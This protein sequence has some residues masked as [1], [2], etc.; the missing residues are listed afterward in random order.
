MNSVLPI[1]MLPARSPIV[2]FLRKTYSGLP[3][4]MFT[5]VGVR[6]IWH[7][8]LG[9]SRIYPPEEI[10]AG[11]FIPRSAVD[12]ATPP[13]TLGDHARQIP[14]ALATDHTNGYNQDWSPWVCYYFFRS[15]SLNIP[16]SKDMIVF[17]GFLRDETEVV[18]Q[19]LEK[20]TVCNDRVKGKDFLAHLQYRHRTT[21]N[22]QTYSCLWHR[23]SASR[24][25]IKSSLERHMREQH[26]PVKWACPTCTRTF[27]R[28]TTL[29]GHF[30]RCL[31]H[32]QSCVPCTLSAQER[33]HY[34]KA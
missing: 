16:S 26:F 8:D 17:N 30:K 15:R 31:G 33:D 29:M 23:C 12:T 14:V 4:K 27:T 1:F 13:H 7:G 3:L 22:S 32:L 11:P 6:S 34:R 21:S 5:S 19:W 20:T 24:P 28:K 25:M 10:L 2:H 9:S 18:C